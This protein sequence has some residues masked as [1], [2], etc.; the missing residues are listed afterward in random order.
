MRSINWTHSHRALLQLVTVVCHKQDLAA[1]MKHNIDGGG[2]YIRR[3]D[4]WTATMLAAAY[5]RWGLKR[6][7]IEEQ[8]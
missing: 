5:R 3:G 8:T 2:E 1:L 7:P 4:R 6:V